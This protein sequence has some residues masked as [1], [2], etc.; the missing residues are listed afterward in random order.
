M[1]EALPDIRML[2]LTAQIV[3]AQ[4]AKNATQMDALPGLIRSVYASLTEAG[5]E[6]GSERRAT[7]AGGAGEEVH[8]PELPGL[9]GRRQKAEN[10]EAASG[11]R[12]QIDPGAVPRAVGLAVGLSD[13]GAGVCGAA[14]A[15]GQGD[16]PGPQGCAR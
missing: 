9:P 10:A 2:Q 15:T 5:Q 13:G 4:V 7:G 8:L 14:V 12:L 16:R 6:A 1:D 3:S 11:H